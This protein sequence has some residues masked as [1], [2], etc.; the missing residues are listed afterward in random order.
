MAGEGDSRSLRGFFLDPRPLA[1]PES[2]VFGFTPGAMRRHYPLLLALFAVLGAAPICSAETAP[3]VEVPPAPKFVRKEGW[4]HA[5]AM[6]AAATWQAAH[7]T[8]RSSLSSEQRADLERR[9]DE[10]SEQPVQLPRAAD[11]YD[12]RVEAATRAISAAGIE[13]LATQKFLI[14]KHQFRQSFEPYAGADVPFFITTDSL[15]NGFHV[16][17][18]DSFKELEI[19]RAV[20]LRQ[21]LEDT[22]A[23]VRAKL[24]SPNLPPEVIEPAWLQAQR[25]IGPAMVLLGSSADHFDDAVR[26]EIVAQV[27][28][29]R[30]ASMVELPS[31]LAPV[32]DD[33]LALD[34]RRLKPVGFYASTSFLAD[35][36]RAVRWLQM[37]PYRVDRDAEL[38]AIALLGAG[39]PRLERNTA[40][41]Y[42]EVY[43]KSLG[44]PDGRSLKDAMLLRLET[45]RPLAAEWVAQLRARWKWLSE[46][47]DRGL[48]NS[49]LRMASAESATQRPESF[50]VLAGYR[51]PD[52]TLFQRLADRGEEVTGLQVAALA[53]LPWAEAK[54]KT[55]QSEFA[56]DALQK[57]VEQLRPEGELRF[58]A[59]LYEKYLDV[60][61]ALGAPADPDAPA[62][63]SSEAWA[64]KSCQ[65]ALASWTQMRHTFTLQAKQAVYA[66][67]ASE[68]PPGFVEP[69]PL[70]LR[71]FVELVEQTRLLL[72]AEGVFQPSG[73][74][75]SAELCEKADLMVRLADG[76]R[77]SKDRDA[78]LSLPEYGEVE[79]YRMNLSGSVYVHIGE[80]TWDQVFG[81]LKDPIGTSGVFEHCAEALREVASRYQ[82]GELKPDAERAYESLAWRWKELGKLTVRLE[83]LVQKQLRQREWTKEEAAFIKSYGETLASIMGYFGIGYTPRD[84]AP[85]WVEIVRD[86][87]GNDSLVAATGRPRAFYAL[88]P[89]HGLE[90]L[91]E[92]AVIP[93]Y[94]YRATEILTD[95]EWREQLG[96]PDVPRPPNWTDGLFDRR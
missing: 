57:A 21:T 32:T 94:E 43:E 76:I 22:I 79:D 72:D 33:L 18:E 23:N 10:E 28:K 44:E 2:R 8:W 37:V 20:R 60:I 73:E 96:R 45:D 19:R 56:R 51:L 61:G 92:G 95:A 48:V 47:R 88:Y 90:V 77:K 91:C 66:L 14:G 49:D 4:T 30:D 52:A 13:Q 86:P 29:I 3:K 42:F 46:P 68:L 82:R 89:W 58:T 62:F 54:L 59:S 9:A 24:E 27:A 81:A 55:T 93:Y 83:S 67:C 71:R 34:Y 64:A 41:S 26:S 7:Q 87:R 12:W 53:G 36:F 84:D 25:A 15:L 78:I 80:R 69:N 50:R 35:Y 11:G 39:V 17:F 1:L 31:W 85:R 70:F 75:V 74:S 5:E 65:T 16:L 63:M 6:A 40:D 38:G